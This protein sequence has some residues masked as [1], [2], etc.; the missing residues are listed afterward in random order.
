MKTMLWFERVLLSIGLLLVGWSGLV[1]MEARFVDA[2]GMPIESPALAT[3]AAAIP[4]G[5]WVARLEAPS[6]GLSAT[7]LEGSDDKTL[8]KAA[9]HIE[10]TPLPGQPGNIGIAGHRDTTFRRVRHLKIGDTL[11][12]ATPEATFE[13]RIAE[14]RIVDPDAVDVL[15][16][17][18]QP[19]L[20]LVTCYPFTF[21]GNAPKRYILRAVLTEERNAEGKRRGDPFQ[22][23]P[24]PV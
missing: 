9:G 16:P 23:R 12:L 13:Y 6:V 2:M 4:R 18:T 11:R 17:T 19:S 20:T 14:T 24:K 7:V 5:T 15:A 21:I 1:L 10:S 22:S 8:D 3:T